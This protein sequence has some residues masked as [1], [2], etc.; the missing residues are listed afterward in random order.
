MSGSNAQRGKVEPQWVVTHTGRTFGDEWAGATT[1]ERRAM[2][3]EAG[4]RLDVRKGRA[5]GWRKLDTRRVDFTMS[6]ELDPAAESVAVAAG[7]DEAVE[8]NETPPA[9]GSSARL[10][11]TC[12]ER[13]TVAA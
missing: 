8:R 12:Q 9:P 11:E 3:M 1:E 5:G 13:V 6:G 10:T 2:L 4:V 7:D